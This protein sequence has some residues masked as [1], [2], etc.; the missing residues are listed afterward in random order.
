MQIQGAPPVTGILEDPRSS[1]ASVRTLSAAGPWLFLVAIVTAFGLYTKWLEPANFFSTYHDD[2]VYFS[3]AAALAQGRGYILPSVPGTPPQT[4]YPVFY[5]WV[6]SWVWRLY[7]SFP[8]NVVPASWLTVGFACLFLVLSVLMLRKLPLAGEW[9]ALLCVMFCAFHPVFLFLSICVLSDI[10]FIA[11]AM[12][13]ML[14]ADRAFADRNGNRFVIAAA[15]LACLCFLTRVAGVAVIV[16]IIL[17]GAYRSSYRRVALFLLVVVPLL[18][19]HAWWSAGRQSQFADA[20]TGEIAW[21]QTW[22]WYTN[23]VEYWKLSIPDLPTFGAMLSYNLRELLLSPSGFCLSLP[24]GGAT[25]VAGTLFS[26]T[27]TAGILSGLIRQARQGNWKTIHFVLPLYCGML[28]LLNYAVFDRYLILFLPLFYAG[29]FVEGR[30]ILREI[31]RALSSR[32]SVLEVATAGVLG[33]LVVGVAASTLYQ[34]LGNSRQGL[35]KMGRARVALM[36]EK[37]QVYDW[38]RRNTEPSDRFV[39]YEDADLYLH[40]GRQAMRPIAFATGV[41]YTGDSKALQAQL[42][43][44]PSVARRIGARY[45]VSAEGDFDMDLTSPLLNKKIAEL[46]AVLPLVHQSSSGKVRVY[47]L[48]CLLQATEARCAAAAQVLL[49]R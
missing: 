2:T 40:T 16:G 10:P 11:L 34:Y 30:Y 21:R 35:Q 24:L 22:A 28:L 12:G 20:N 36:Q 7:P 17:A 44:F 49:A 37:R 41:V 25:S 8:G 9:T 47:D 46:Q 31:A 48:S 15:V 19:L 27:L 42:D 1:A 5:S 26:I 3:S 32:R 29:V 39:S 14:A 45:W 6:L 18:S 38:I 43:Q 23:Y 13:A 33:V 4:K